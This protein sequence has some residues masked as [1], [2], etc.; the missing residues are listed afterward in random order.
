MGYFKY[1]CAFW[2]THNCTGWSW[3]NNDP[4]ANCLGDGLETFE[5]FSS[6]M[7]MKDKNITAERLRELYNQER[8]EAT[9]RRIEKIKDKAK[10]TQ[11]YKKFLAESELK[12]KR[13]EAK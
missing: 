6:R 7:R 8:A 3:L 2:L 12:P 4:C 10:Q 13:L 5:A 9:N 11:D 1:R